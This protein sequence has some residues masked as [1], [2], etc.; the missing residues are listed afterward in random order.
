M[1][2]LGMVSR[3]RRALSF[4]DALVLFLRGQRAKVA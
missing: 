4:L 3:N 2:S 1:N